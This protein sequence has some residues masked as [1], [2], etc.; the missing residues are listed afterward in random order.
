[1]KRVTVV[2]DHG[3]LVVNQPGGTD[4]PGDKPAD[5]GGPQLVKVPPIPAGM[6][7]PA[8][9]PADAG[10]VAGQSQPGQLAGVTPTTGPADATTGTGPATQPAVATADDE[11]FEAL[12]ARFNA[13]TKLPLGEQ[14]IDDL[15]GRYQKVVDA[16]TAPSSMLQIA[17]FRLK[18]L[19][20][21]KEAAE[22]LKQ[23]DAEKK[24]RESA[25]MPLREE[26]KE[27]SQR[28]AANE[29][30]RYTAVGTLR[31]SSLPSNGKTLYRL[32][33]PATGRTVIYL[34][35]AS[36]DAISREGTF[37]GV[38]GPITDDTAR[39]IKLINPQSIETVDP[40]DLAKGT[41]S[42]GMVPPSLASTS[43]AA[44]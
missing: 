15:I 23:G 1:M 43:D 14:P 3:R 21:R 5:N 22:T 33:D 7:N 13:A 31:A 35:D 28:M 18:G 40:A 30:K 38:R 17:D 12:E 6:E 20:L 37:V 34:T 44:R 25:Q 36:A 26:A 27:I 11:S 8:T 41:V 16:K 9:Q 24:A 4:K 39:Q 29:S 10:T 2:N 32:T 19:A 42:S